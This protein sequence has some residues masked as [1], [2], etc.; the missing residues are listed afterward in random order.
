M[1]P[2][3]RIAE[4]ISK[5]RGTYTR[6]AITQQL[7]DAGY[8]REAID[9]TWAALETPDPDSPP[10]TGFWGRFWWMLI[11]VNVVVLLAIGLLTGLLTNLE[12]GAVLLVVL[13]V[14]LAIGALI[15][16]GIVAATGPDKMS[17][18]GSTIVGLTIPLVIALLIGGGCYALVGSIG[19]PPRSG[20]LELDAGELAGSGPA[21]CYVG[22]GGGGF[23]V[24]GQIAGDPPM[25][26]DLNN[27]PF[28][29]GPPTDEVRNVSV[30]VENER[31][32]FYSTEGSN[33][34]LT[35]E[36]ADAGVSG[37]VSFSDL[38]SDASGEASEGAL[39]EAISGTVTWTC[40]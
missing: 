5:Q 36:V 27:F 10:D 7:L 26:V 19:P 20:T 11:G 22:Q 16:W 30:F 33:A 3:R 2:D 37:T 39:P 35:S 14:V 15:A 25:T 34:E 8:S 12:Q 13:A 40:D 17:R 6:E 18:T 24:F 23:S 31:G 38:R 9:A 4:F 29:A 28:D 21:T 32:Q 1:G